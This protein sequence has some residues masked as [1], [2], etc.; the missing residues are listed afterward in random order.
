MN[1]STKQQHRTPYVGSGED[2]ARR[3]AEID[4]EEADRVD[5]FDS[6]YNRLLESAESWEA[7]ARDLMLERLG[8]RP[9]LAQVGEWAGS[10]EWQAGLALLALSPALTANAAR[11]TTWSDGGGRYDYTG[12]GEER[13]AVFTP[14]PGMD[15][16]AWAADVDEHGRGW[17]STEWRLFELIAGITVRDRRVSLTEVFNLGSWEREALT[18][19]VEWA[20]GGNQRDRPGR[21]HLAPRMR[22]L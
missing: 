6:R 5:I 17:S 16:A 12:E 7:Q 11:F 20:S 10:E 18:I 13:V 21:Y 22:S 14:N 2:G 19:V 9:S 3:S 15:W 4:R 1:Q 8:P